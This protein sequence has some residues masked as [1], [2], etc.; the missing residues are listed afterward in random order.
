MKYG[1]IDRNNGTYSGYFGYHSTIAL[2]AYRDNTCYQP[3]ELSKNVQTTI[4]VDR[5]TNVYRDFLSTT[6]GNKVHLFS[7][8][9]AHQRWNL[10]KVSEKDDELYTIRIPDAGNGGVFYLGCSSNAS[11]VALVS[12]DDG[13]GSQHWCFKE[14]GPGVY[15]ILS[16]GPDRDSLSIRHYPDNKQYAFLSTTPEGQVDLYSHDDESGRQ[17]W[18][19]EEPLKLAKTNAITTILLAEIQFHP[20]Q[21]FSSNP[22]SVHHISHDAYER[23]FYTLG[24]DNV[25]EKA[26]EVEIQKGKLRKAIEIYYAVGMSRVK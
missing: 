24:K 10:V 5:G 13:S 9:T 11:S 17:Q 20:E 15:N 3:H 18:I 7:K 26:G 22:E 2:R 25:K 12:E 1:D 8:K 21:L 16:K 6:A 4:S 23:L 19:F 14:V